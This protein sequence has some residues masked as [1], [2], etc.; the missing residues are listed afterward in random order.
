MFVIEILFFYIKIK[1]MGKKLNISKTEIITS[2]FKS[3]VLPSLLF[4]F[5][6]YDDL[7]FN[8]LGLL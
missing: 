7:R 3:N 8:I 1:F 6:S 4:F 5:A 2:V